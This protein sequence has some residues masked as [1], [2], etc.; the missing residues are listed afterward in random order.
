[1]DGNRFDLNSGGRAAPTP[2]PAARRALAAGC[3]TAA[4]LLVAAAPARAIDNCTAEASVDV[5][6]CDDDTDLN[7]AFTPT[8][9][10]LDIQDGDT[11]TIT[12]E[13]LN[14]SSFNRMPADPT[15]P[16]SAELQVGQTVSVH[17]S[18]TASTCGAGQVLAN[19]FVFN[20]VEWLAPGVSFSD[21]GNGQTGTIT[22][23]APGV[24]FPRSDTMTH[25]LV[26]LK[27]TAASPPATPGATVFARAEGSP[28]LLLITDDAAPTPPD[29]YQCLPGLT[30]TGEGSVAGL[31][32]ANN[33]K[34]EVCQH[35]NKQV[36][37]IDWRTTQLE[38]SNSRIGFVLPG[39]DPATSSLAFGYANSGGSVFT[40]PAVSGFVQKTAKCWRY[41][42]PNARSSPPAVS[43]ARLC[44]I[45]PDKWC[46]DVQGFADF[47][48]SLPNDRVMW[49]TVDVNGTD[50]FAG[51][52]TPDYAQ[53]ATWLTIPPAAAPPQ[54]ANL[55]FL[56]QT[57]WQ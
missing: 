32:G 25:K 3:I 21:D 38:R 12:V 9:N 7:P 39:F 57:A 2:G 55:W 48:A 14:T 26:R 4:L 50:V 1:M 46:L 43:S 51:P 49:M 10:P 6:Y 5:H 15:D 28:A 17:Y 42:D 44:E 40:Y 37:T 34:L 52:K 30:G 13:V 35:P 16:P 29:T 8:C 24:S 47:N 11:V 20:S 23:I 19:W 27:L 36:I 45:A 18:C 41:R 22:I 54:N 56:P 31:F 33:D 53:D